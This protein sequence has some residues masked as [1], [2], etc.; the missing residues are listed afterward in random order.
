MRILEGFF[1]VATTS[2]AVC[3]GHATSRARC[4]SAKKDDERVAHFIV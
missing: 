3:A 1:P 2:A 4:S